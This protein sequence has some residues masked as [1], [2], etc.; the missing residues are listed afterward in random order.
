[1]NQ[2]LRFT[3]VVALGLLPIV[4]TSLCAEQNSNDRMSLDG[5]W[6]IVFDDNNEGREL[7]WHQNEV[8]TSLSGKKPIAVPSAWELTEQDYE[9]VAFYR[10]TFSVPE[11]WKEKNVHLKFG[12]VNYLAEVW[13]N[14]EVVGYHKGGFTPFEFRVDE[15]VKFGEE[16]VLTLRVVSQIY[17]SGKN[18]DGF[19]PL[20]TPGW[21]GGI[22]G[23]NFTSL[24]T[25]NSNGVNP[26][27]WYPTTS[28]FS[29]TSA[30]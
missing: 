21:R 30:R 23:P 8:F 9:G 17:L 13:L 20:Q 10:T 28:S 29:Q 12:A 7:D 18:I 25:R 16:N 5:T 2:S 4:V 26:P 24:S 6:E 22:S 19:G 15:L 1:M 14:D 27:S 11:E 3:S